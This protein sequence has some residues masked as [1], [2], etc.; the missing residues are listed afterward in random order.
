MP[1]T[2]DERKRQLH[3]RLA[4]VATDETQ[5]TNLV[6]SLLTATP[7]YVGVIRDALNPYKETVAATLWTEFHAEQADAD[8]R[9]R[10]AMALARYVPEI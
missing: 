6:E 9:F 1:K 7:K 10:A 2:A 5:A 3:A 8:R 4:L